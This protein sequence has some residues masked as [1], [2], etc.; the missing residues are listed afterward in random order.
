VVFGDLKKIG[1]IYFLNRE[2]LKKNYKFF[3]NGKFSPQKIHAFNDAM[4]FFWEL[5]FQ[6]KTNDNTYQK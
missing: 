3:Q 1:L 2:L 4:K 5:Y 6:L